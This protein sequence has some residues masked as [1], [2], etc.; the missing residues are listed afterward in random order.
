MPLEILLRGN[1]VV[2][3]PAS[4]RI[5]MRWMAYCLFSL[6]KY[7]GLRNCHDF[8]LIFPIT[9][10]IVGADRKRNSGHNRARLLY[11]PILGHPFLTTRASVLRRFGVLSADLFGMQTT[12]LYYEVWLIQCLRR[13]AQLE[14]RCIIWRSSLPLQRH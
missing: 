9:C 7:V 13:Y 10:C 1:Q 8:A 3:L 14:A 11:L 5:K 2:S 12:R 4:Q 6:R